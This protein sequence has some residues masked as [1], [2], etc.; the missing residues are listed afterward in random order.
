MKP[1]PTHGTKGMTEDDHRCAYCHAINNG[2]R[3]GKTRLP[4]EDRPLRHDYD[5]DVKMHVLP[6]N[7]AAAA[8]WLRRIAKDPIRLAQ[9]ELM[10]RRMPGVSKERFNI[11]AR[12]AVREPMLN[13]DPQSIRNGLNFNRSAGKVAGRRVAK[14]SVAARLV[15]KPVTLQNA[16]YGR[17]SPFWG[18]RL[19]TVFT[20]KYSKGYVVQTDI[21]DDSIVFRTQGEL[22]AAIKKSGW[23]IV[24]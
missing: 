6:H 5:A 4:R 3:V 17:N 8:E 19:W 16:K 21:G 14:Q 23:E 7:Q 11:A 20:L 1:C 15:I 12:S 24:R 13:A 2:D 10:G 9:L 22:H 18:E